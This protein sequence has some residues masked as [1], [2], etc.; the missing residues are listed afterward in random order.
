MTT[1][2]SS[3]PW[4][5]AA[6]PPDVFRRDVLDGLKRPQKEIPCK[7]LYD[8]TGSA[9]F[10]RICEL[11]EYYP[12]RLELGI[13]HHH[14]DEIAETVGP[15]ALLV[16]F[17]SGNSRKTRVLLDRL[18]RLQGYVPIDI[19]TATLAHATARL[20]SR[21]PDLEIV[22]MSADYTMPFS[23][24]PLAGRPTVFFPGSTVGNFAPPEA[25]AFLRRIRAVCGDE[26]SLLIGVDLQKDVR[27]LQAAYDD[28]HGVTAA[29]NLNLLRRINREIG[30]GFVL[31]SFDHAATYNGHHHR[32]EMHLV[33]RVR[34]DVRV[35]Q[36][37]VSFDAGETIHT[38]NS[39]KYTL[40][41]FAELAYTAGFQ[42][43]R[44][45]T[46]THHF[47]SVQHLVAQSG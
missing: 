30:A 42:V 9:L 17:G 3:S 18:Q 16:E 10:E 29:F 1:G 5:D 21:Y 33:S 32:M 26:G 47:F 25:V 41:G 23:L 27:V 15:G 12:T 4:Y 38:E 44:V 11:D 22:A 24:P 13:L 43:K 35:A 19:A 28:A 37:M 2:S 40:D 7:Y 46:D 14:I 36:H 45:W 6:A 8:A 31:A 34:Q 39:Y 20:R